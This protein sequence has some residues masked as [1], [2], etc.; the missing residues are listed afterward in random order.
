VQN[1]LAALQHLQL[2]LHLAIFLHSTFWH[3]PNRRALQAPNKVGKIFLVSLCYANGLINTT[4]LD[5]QQ[6]A[7]AT[8]LSKESG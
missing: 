5:L 7:K 3:L 2:H 8:I 1:I 6:T 4:D